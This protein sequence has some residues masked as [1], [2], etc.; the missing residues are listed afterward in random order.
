MRSWRID[1]HGPPSV[2]SMVDLPDPLPGPGEVLLAVDAVGLNHLDLWVRRGVAGH[3]FPLPITPGCDVA[4]TVLRAGP[5]VFG[6]APGESVIVCPG[7]GCGDCSACRAGQEVLCRSYGIIGETRDGGCGERIVVRAESLMRRPSNLSPEEA[8]AVPL[9]LLTAWR[10]VVTRAAL[11][12]GET[13]LVHAAGSGIGVMAIQIARSIGARI[14]A[15]AGSAE[16]AQRAIALGAEEVILYRESDF[17]EEVRR[18]TGKRGVDVVIEHTGADTFEKSVRALAKGG[19]LVTC[20]ATS[21]PMATVDLRL[22]F[23]KSLSIL[24]STMGNAAE[25]ETAMAQVTGGKIRPVI[26]SVFPMAEL[27]AAHEYLESRRAFGKV[28][29]RGFDR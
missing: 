18:L 10:M 21:G 9:T 4:G 20:G 2:L 23:F 12:P 28:V 15:T 29:M 19:R 5:E 6:W 26:D 24:G 25:L 7:Y 8:A 11:Q 17:L 13:I 16:K 22:V 27:P 1:H 3:R 14:L